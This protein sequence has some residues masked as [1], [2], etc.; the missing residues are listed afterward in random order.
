MSEY[1]VV[2]VTAANFL[3]F[4]CCSALSWTSPELPKLVNSTD[5]PFYHDL[6]NE[7]QSWIGAFL[8]LGAIFGPIIFGYL[9]DRFG[10][11]ATLLSISVPMQACFLM[12]A[13]A[14][15]IYLFYIA[16]FVTGVAVGGSF[17]VLPMYIAEMSLDHHRGV[18]AVSMSVFICMGVLFCYAVGPYM[19][20][21]AFNCLLAAIA[22]SFFVIFFIV[23]SE[24]PHYHVFKNQH[25]RA[26]EV[27]LRIRAQS[28]EATEKELDQIKHVIENEESAGFVD[29]FT[30]KGLRKAEIISSALLIFQQFSGINAVLFYSEQIFQN[31]GSSLSGEYCAMIVGVVQLISCVLTASLAN[32][33][34]RRTLLVLSGFGMALAEVTLGTYSYLDKNGTDVSAMSFLP[35]VSLVVY[36]VMYNFGFG[37]ISWTVLSEMFPTNVRALATALNTSLCWVTSFFITKYFSTVSDSFGIGVCFLAFSVACFAAGLFSYFCVLETKGK[38]LKQIQDELNS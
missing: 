14:K 17:T 29:I 38:S 11:K 1:S 36:I 2:S 8:P 5:S 13:F 15:E 28:D 24:T 22:A 4:V 12:Q 7:Q 32:V 19:S 18:L 6:S 10:R 25:D 31:A 26:K 35:I 23:G 3:A 16:R 34:G 9:S 27:L 21:V 30:V 33:F 20:I 37:P